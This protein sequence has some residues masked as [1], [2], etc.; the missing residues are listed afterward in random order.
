SRDAG[1]A[2]GRNAGL[3]RA[4]ARVVLLID[5]SIEPTGDVVAPLIEALRDP[6]VG[7]TGPFGIVTDDLRQFHPSDGP[8]V[9][10]IEGYVMAFRRELVESGLRFDEK[11]KFYRTADIELS[12]QVK[13][14]GLR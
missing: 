6:G 8:D 3:R 11:F 13:A 12:F 4:A 2:S 9:A 7:V 5:G 14:M 1:W 10:A